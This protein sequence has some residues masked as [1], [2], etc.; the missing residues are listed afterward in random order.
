MRT[1]RLA[2]LLALVTVL[3]GGCAR[4][5][6]PSGGPPDLVPPTLLA[7][8][9]DSGSA[10][11][12]LD[13]RLSV[14]FSEGMEPRSAG[15]AVALAPRVDIRQRR[16]HGRTLTLVLDDTLRASQTYTLFVSSAARDRHG[17]RMIAGRTIVF[18]T[19]DTFP[20]GLIEGRIQARGFKAEGTYL[21]CYRGGRAPDSTARD[22]DALGLA[23][24]DGHFRISGLA[25]PGQYRLWAFVDLN[26]NRSFEPDK[27]VL[28]RSDTTLELTPD[29]P[30]ASGIVLRVTDPRAPGHVRGLVVDDTG[31]SLGVLRVVAISVEDSTRRVAS[32]PDAK[33]TFDL[34]LAAG[35]WDVRAWRDEDRNRAW[36]MDLEPASPAERVTV[37]PAGE[38]NDLHLVLKRWVQQP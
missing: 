18:S 37:E 30:V 33:R 22:F 4:K 2:A 16:W 21:W 23:D 36:R 15:D 19:A 12:P 6:P 14:T 10:R 27:D 5:G 31:D 29:R 25:V 3:A 32:E 9:P 35:E 17:N 7:A 20:P 13:A 1:L 28:A 11:V 26:L 38:I 24:E 8:D 34:Q